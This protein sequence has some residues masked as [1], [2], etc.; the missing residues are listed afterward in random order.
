[1]PRAGKKKGRRKESG[2]VGV[3]CVCVS[4][5]VCV[6]VW[7]A[8]ICLRQ[9]AVVCMFCASGGASLGWVGDW[10]VK[11][12][13]RRQ[14]IC[15]V[16]SMSTSYP[17]FG[18]ASSCPPSLYPTCSPF[19]VSLLPLLA[20]LL[21]SSLL[22]AS[23]LFASLLFASLRFSSLLFASL[24]FSS[25]L[26][27]SLLFASLLLAS[28]VLPARAG[29]EPRQAL[30]GARPGGRPADQGVRQPRRVHGREDLPP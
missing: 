1:L 25:L 8:N 18:T 26:F 16:S 9:G 28:Q 15:E 12:M 30:H 14:A 10:I 11:A 7:C 27:A 22:F 20:S 5:C 29:P 19:A 13:A 6:C 2:P 24:R 3:L 23:L 21:F 4:V 17:R